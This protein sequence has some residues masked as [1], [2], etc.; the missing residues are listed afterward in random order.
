M[1]VVVTK[2]FAYGHDGIYVEQMTVGAEAEIRD[3]LVSGLIKEGFVSLL[4]AP[5]TPPTV[6]R[7]GRG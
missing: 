7:K 1:K 2:S 3:E 4:R 5:E 6:R